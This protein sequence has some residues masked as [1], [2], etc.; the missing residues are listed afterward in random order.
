M[1]WNLIS[2]LTLA[3][4]ACVCVSGC[5]SATEESASASETTLASTTAGDC[6]SSQ[7][8]CD[9]C[10]AAAIAE[11]ESA[12]TCSDCNACAEGDSANCKC[13]HSAEEKKEAQADTKTETINES[14]VPQDA[15]EVLSFTEDRDIFHFLLSNKD[16]ITRQVKELENGVETL[17]ESSNPEIAAKIQTH[18]ASMYQRVED[19]RP[20]R[21]RDPLYREVFKHAD[22]IKM[23]LANTDTGIRVTETAED[24]YVVKLIQAH[25]KVVSGFVEKGFAE[26]RLNHEP[27]QR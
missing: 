13:G 21:M 27:P 1:N 11:K 15:D 24:E 20:I 8:G 22:E 7:A 5:N 25:A 16:E 4:G 26:A 10:A 3:V 19:V 18:V 14:D 9:K 12:D 17:T 23:K 6:C 2:L